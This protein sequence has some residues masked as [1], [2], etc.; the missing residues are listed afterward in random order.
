M[1][2]RQAAIVT[3][4]TGCLRRTDG[5]TKKKINRLAVKKFYSARINVTVGVFADRKQM[6]LRRFPAA[7]NS[8]DGK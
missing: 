5:R 2:S 3:P 8:E 4:S 1:L 7:G 6:I